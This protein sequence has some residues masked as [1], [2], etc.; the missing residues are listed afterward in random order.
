MSIDLGTATGGAQILTAGPTDALNE[1]NSSVAADSPEVIATTA[2]KSVWINATP[3][4]NWSTLTAGRYSVMITYIDYGA[5]NTN[6][7]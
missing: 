3:S 6:K 7:N 4:A 1:I 2:A 5:V